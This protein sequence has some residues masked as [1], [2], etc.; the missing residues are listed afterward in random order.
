MNKNES[1]NCNYSLR[2]FK[3][4]LCDDP[5]RRLHLCSNGEE[6]RGKRKKT[7]PQQ[8]QRA[9][10]THS[11]TDGQALANTRS[12]PPSLLSPLVG[13]TVAFSD[14]VHLR[15][16]KPLSRFQNTECQRQGVRDFV[17]H[18]ADGEGMCHC[19]H[20]NS[21]LCHSRSGDE[22][23]LSLFCAPEIACVDVNAHAST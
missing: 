12:L 10:C 22:Q 5:S 17:R 4:P 6:G 3:A 2:S 1:R 14:N 9:S 23:L 16:S 7:W 13:L 21:Q 20:C 19:H 11:K 15:E 18:C 8:T